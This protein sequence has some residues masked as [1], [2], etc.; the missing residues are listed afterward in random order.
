MSDLEQALA[1]AETELARRR[2]ELDE[3]RSALALLHVRIAEERAQL[4]VAKGRQL[5]LRERFKQ[6]Y[7]GFTRPRQP[8]ST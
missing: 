4:E 3:A 6:I 5:E 1:A 7:E 8:P 2:R